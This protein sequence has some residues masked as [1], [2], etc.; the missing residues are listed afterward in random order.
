[1]HY[2]HLME[3]QLHPSIYAKLGTQ[4]LDFF[5]FGVTP[6]SYTVVGCTNRCY[7]LV[8]ESASSESFIQL[9]VSVLKYNCMCCLYV[10]AVS[11]TSQCGHKIFWDRRVLEFTSSWL[12]LT[13][14]DRV[15]RERSSEVDWST[16]PSTEFAIALLYICTDKFCHPWTDLFPLRSREFLT[17]EWIAIFRACTQGTNY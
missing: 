8:P 17:N 5:F 13:R 9:P 11:T 16:L 4:W 2:T 14:E 15:L 7:T 12:L 10:L 1:M 6:A 3:C